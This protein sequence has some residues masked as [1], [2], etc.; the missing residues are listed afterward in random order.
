MKTTPE[1]ENIKRQCWICS[2]VYLTQPTSKNK[3][4]IGCKKKW[5]KFWNYFIK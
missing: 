4:C 2:D 5:W 3:T 1:K